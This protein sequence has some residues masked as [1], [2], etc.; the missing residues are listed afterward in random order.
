M[1]FDITKELKRTFDL[2]DMRH[3]TR[4][5]RKAEDWEQG[6]A[7]MAK[8]QRQAKVQTQSYYAQYDTRVSQALQRLM[9]KAGTPK[10]TLTN[11]FFQTDQFNKDLLLRQAHKDVQQDHHRRISRIE[12]NE[13]KELGVLIEKIERR[14]AKRE[15]MKQ[16]FN[17]S[18][19]KQKAKVPLKDQPRRG[20]RRQ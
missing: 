12:H 3:K 17:R 5:F 10:K 18:A 6:R 14:D 16:S 9:D 2:A 11:R 15:E 4:G 7:I 13:A 1:P 8:Y 20:P 19:D